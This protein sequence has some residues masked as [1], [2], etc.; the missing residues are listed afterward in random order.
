MLNT[1]QSIVTSVFTV[2]LAWLWLPGISL[3]FFYSLTWLQSGLSE[4]PT[5]ILFL[6][7]SSLSITIACYSHCRKNRI[8]SG[9]LSLPLKLFLASVVILPFSRGYTNALN[10]PLPGEKPDINPD[11]FI[12]RMTAML[13]AIIHMLLVSVPV[14]ASVLAIGIVLAHYW[15]NL[16]NKEPG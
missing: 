9:F 14:L 6:V 10:E 2:F 4:I 12:S 8:D 11:V 3:A 13:D 16:R 5:W 1:N 15:P 7:I